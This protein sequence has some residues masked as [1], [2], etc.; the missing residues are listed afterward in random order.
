VKEID[1]TSVIGLDPKPAQGLTLIKALD[2][3][4]NDRSGDLRV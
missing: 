2:T 4:V 3:K 1:D